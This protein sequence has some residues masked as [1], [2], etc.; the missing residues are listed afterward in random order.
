VKY[1]KLV[2]LVF[3]FSSHL[4]AEDKDLENIFKKNGINGAVII[5]SLNNDKKYIYNNSRAEKRYIPAS[6][7]KILNT[8]IALDQK[9]INNENDIIKW[10]GKKRFY[11]PWNQDQTLKSAISIS[12]VWCYQKFARKIGNKNYLNY[13]NKNHYGNEKTGSELAT[14]WLDGDLKISTYEHI[15]FL[16]NLYNNNMAFQQKHMNI[17]K[18]ILT[19]EKTNTYI[20]KAKS[21]WAKKIGWYIGYVETKNDVW[22]FALN[23]DIERSQLKYR[24]EII[25]NALKLKS[26]I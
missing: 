24:K 13:L 23:A 25:M 18:E 26:I 22:F 10:D 8:L 5:S 15:E 3:L 6:T 2:M 9:V 7:F 12:C 1:I 20:I 17:T 4:M 14:F 21:G 11:S 16:Q 19:V